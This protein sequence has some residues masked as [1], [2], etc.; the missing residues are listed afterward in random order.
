VELISNSTFSDNSA[1]SSGAINNFSG[2]IKEISNST[3][4][5]NFAF[6]VGG[7][8]FNQTSADSVAII[9]KI[10]NSTF[11]ENSAWSGGAIWNTG[12][13][14]ISFTTISGNQSIRA[15]GGGIVL[16][17]PPP[18]SSSNLIPPPCGDGQIS[19][20]QYRIRN[21]IIAFNTP[22]NCTGPFG[23]QD[24]GGNYSDDFSCGFTGDGSEIILAGGL[25]NNGGPTETMALLGGDPVDGA[26][27]NCDALNEMG[28]PTGIP[29]GIDQRYFPRPF[30]IRCD[31]GAFED[32]PSA[33]VTITKVTDPA[34]GSD[35]DFLFGSNGFN[36]LQDC[37]LDGGG[38]GMFALNDGDSITCIVP[39]GD[40][41]I[42]ENIQ[43]GYE[44]LIF[45]LEAPDNIVINNETGDINFTI[46]DSGS[47]VDCIYTNV[48]IE[49]GGGGGG[50][51]V[52]PAG[53]SNS[54][55]LYLFIPVLIL[56]K[57]IVKRYRN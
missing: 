19:I 12:L 30:G 35:D 4:N 53:T 2:T 41:S 43:Q 45:C 15:G 6:D 16:F 36:P 23:G 52:A 34:G 24:I 44:L 37:P 51:S 5:G 46:E 31:S 28:N 25:A 29:I 56:I 21:S 20:G 13:I 54:I 49:D 7:A 57:R 22:K 27:V 48:R 33:T 1:S 26:T 18:C 8:I 40:Y 17:P 42:K 38:D 9:E 3:F 11:N 32:S 39:Q 47:D 14:N 10:V 50:C 55:P